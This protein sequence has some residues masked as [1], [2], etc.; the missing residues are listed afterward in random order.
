MGVTYRNNLKN[1]LLGV[2]RKMVLLEFENIKRYR[3]V[4]PMKASANYII[5]F[6]FSIPTF[7]EEVIEGTI[8]YWS[9]P[10][11]SYVRFPDKDSLFPI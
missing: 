1:S 3:C 6:L 11:T 7:L 10:Y 2:V 5:I 8:P 9:E 4:I